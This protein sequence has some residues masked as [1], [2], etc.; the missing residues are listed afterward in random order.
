MQ[1]TIIFFCKAERRAEKAGKGEETV[2]PEVPE[3]AEKR[4]SESKG[5]RRADYDG[6][7]RVEP[8][9]AAADAQGKG[10]KCGG[11]KQGIERIERA[12]ERMPRAA[13]E[14]HGAQRVIE[15]GKAGAEQKRAGK[16][17]ELGRDVA[18]HAS[19]PEQAAEQSARGAGGV[20]VKE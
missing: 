17:G 5:E 9:L 11:E 10:K 3:R 14:P 12:G 18:A 20:L 19:A 15:Q 8:Q 4:G 2:G 6:E 1:F 13:A 16:H 7:E